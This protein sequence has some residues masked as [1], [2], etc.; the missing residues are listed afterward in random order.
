MNEDT[1]ELI[2]TD[3]PPKHTE[4]TH[5]PY[6]S[7]RIHWKKPS[8]SLDAFHGKWNTT[9]G[10]DESVHRFTL[11]HAASEFE[12]IHIYVHERDSVSFRVMYPLDIRLDTPER[13]V[14]FE[15]AEDPGL[16]DT[17]A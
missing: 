17:H 10:T 14:T 3:C 1:N 15:F 2:T 7:W 8:G 9:V 13:I 11:K 12:V 6:T 16:I 4:Y 5:E